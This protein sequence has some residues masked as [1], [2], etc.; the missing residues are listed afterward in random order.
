MENNSLNSLLTTLKG[1]SESLTPVLKPLSEFME[2]SKKNLTK[3]ELGIYERNLKRMG[4]KVKNS[5]LDIKNT[6]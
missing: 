1:L 3:E 5:I 4:D 2:E 6:H